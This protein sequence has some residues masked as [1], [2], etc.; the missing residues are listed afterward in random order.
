MDLISREAALDCFHD[1]IDRRGDVH[2][3]DEMAE[4]RAIEAL[5]FVESEKRTETHA[6][7][8]ISR[9]AAL[10]ILDD[11]AEDIESGNWGIAYSKARTSMCELP[12]VE[13]ERKFIEKVFET[14][15]EMDDAVNVICNL[16]VDAVLD[17]ME[18]DG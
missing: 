6:C 4:Y 16:D 7:D 11:Y 3:P 18:V 2:T 10:E 13:P 1:W 5:P 9:Q 17:R 8:C 15:R 12:S 14:L